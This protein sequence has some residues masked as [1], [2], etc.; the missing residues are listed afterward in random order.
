M[1]VAPVI[2]EGDGAPVRKAQPRRSLNLHQ[3]QFD[4]VAHEGQRRSATFPRAVFDDAPLG[5]RL[6]PAVRPAPAGGQ[7]NAVR[8]AEGRVVQCDEIVRAAQHGVEKPGSASRRA[9]TSTS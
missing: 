7:Q 8:I 3:E 4:P 5:V 1:A 9:S 6:H 2:S